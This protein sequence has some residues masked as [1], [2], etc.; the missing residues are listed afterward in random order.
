[1]TVGVADKDGNMTFAPVMLRR[2]KKLG[3]SK[4]NP[5]DLTTEEKAK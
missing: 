4:T 1:M 2:L 3:I 5:A